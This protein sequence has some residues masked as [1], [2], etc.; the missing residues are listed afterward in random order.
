MTDCTIADDSAGGN[1]GGVAASLTTLSMANCT[2]EGNI[3]GTMIGYSFA[4]A[5]DGIYCTG[6]LTVSGCAITGNAFG[7]PNPGRRRR[8]IR[9]RPLR[10]DIRQHNYKQRV[11]HH[12]PRMLDCCISGNTVAGNYATCSGYVCT[13]CGGG[14]CCDAFLGAANPD[15]QPGV[16]VTISRNIIGGPTSSLGN[17]SLCGGAG[18]S[19]AALWRLSTRT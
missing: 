18:I 17:T 5:G 7:D 15:F 14:I 12:L 10:H 2:I 11:W 16:V 6:P 9:S 8:H 1:G 19:G 3:A 4:S 13:G